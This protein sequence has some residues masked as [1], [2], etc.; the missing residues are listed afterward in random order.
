MATPEE[1]NR[2]GMELYRAAK[3][4]EAITAYEQA[5][6]LKPDYAPGFINLALANMK[7]N[8]PDA[9]VRAA[10]QATA[11][12]P[13]VGAA[14][15][16]LGNAFNAKGR[17]NEAV[18]SYLRAFELDRNQLAGLVTAGHL[19]QDHGLTPNA[20]EFWRRFLE[21]AAADHPRRSEVDEQLRQ[22]Q[23]ESGLI[24]KF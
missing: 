3:Y 10:Q 13:Q 20:I 7:H 4:A 24:S 6:A 5:V 11:L 14:H 22:A 19:C 1:L 15:N 2:S 23:G 12:A 16:C 9:A 17:W 18:S 8:R 21:A